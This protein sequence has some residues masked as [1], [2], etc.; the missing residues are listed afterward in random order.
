MTA[1][2][3]GMAQAVNEAVERAHREGILTAA[4]LMVSG[5]AAAD[6]IALAERLPTLRVGLHLVLSDGAPA[7]PPEDI[8]DLVDGNGRLKPAKVRA[9]LAHA[10][11]PRIRDQFAREIEAQFAA[12]RK[13][14]LPLDHVNGHEHF[15][16]H[17]G[18][19]R[20]VVEI[21]RRYGMKALRVPREPAAV[22]GSVEPVKTPISVRVMAPWCERLAVR[23]RAAGIRTPDAVFGLR[24]SG[25]MTSERMAGLMRALPP[26]LVEIYTHPASDDCFEGHAPGYRYRAEFDALTDPAVLDLAARLDRPRGGYCDVAGA[27]VLQP[28]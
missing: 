17:P 24:W 27:A 1:D 15:H 5:A 22:L 28:A 23:A 14:G 9:A 16:V 4:S 13:T 21:G 18:L 20:Q 3:F 19:G 11:R 2:D 6:A 7:A 26:G 12:F 10:L 25:H 8:P